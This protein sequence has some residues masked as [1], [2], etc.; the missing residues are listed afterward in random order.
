MIDQTPA[1]NGE[2]VALNLVE[3][4]IIDE[5]IKPGVALADL[6]DRMAQIARDMG[7][8]Y[9]SVTR[10]WREAMERLHAG[11]A[12]DSGGLVGRQELA[13]GDAWCKRW[14]LCLIAKKRHE[15]LEERLGEDPAAKVIKTI[16]YS[17]D[18][19]LDS[20]RA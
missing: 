3:H 11:H 14:M 7:G 16:S 12:V 18:G 17:E 5:L 1:S 20:W 2:L 10:D 4:A 19:S 15:R 8:E 9:S 6:F 13:I